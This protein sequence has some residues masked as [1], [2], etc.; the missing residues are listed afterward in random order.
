MRIT[1]DDYSGIDGLLCSLRMTD[2]DDESKTVLFYL[3]NTIYL[4]KPKQGK[5]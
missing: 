4:D 1:R 5:K 3:R 2:V